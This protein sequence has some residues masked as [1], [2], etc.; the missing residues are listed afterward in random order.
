[1]SKLLLSSLTL[2]EVI[3]K[4][5][6]SAHGY[7]TAIMKANRK[8]ADRHHIIAQKA[9]EELKK[10]GKQDLILNLLNHDAP[11]VRQMAATDTL[12]FAPDS[13][14]PV[15]ERLVQENIGFPSL[16]AMIILQLWRDGKF[17]KDIE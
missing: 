14:I 12:K 10:R 6:N 4:Y 3:E 7:E 9:Y 5:I 15:L 11:I 1:M 16:D 8:E 13:A 2:D 17:L